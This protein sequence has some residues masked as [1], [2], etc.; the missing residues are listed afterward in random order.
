MPRFVLLLT[1]LLVP[2]ILI[3]ACDPSRTPLPD[4]IERDF[5]AIVER[6]TLGAL[7]V[8]NST[9]Y[10]VYRGQPMGY[11]YDLLRAFA[12]AHDLALDVRVV[13][14]PDSLFPLLMEGYGDVAA[15]RLIPPQHEDAR[16]HFTEAVY[17]AQPM[18]VQSEGAPDIP[19]PVVETLEEGA[20]TMEELPGELPGGV[21]PDLAILEAQEEIAIEARPITR[22]E[23]LAGETITLDEG[24][25]YSERLVELSDAV[26]GDIHVVEVSDA[27]MED[28]IR[29][30]AFNEV[31]LTVAPANLAELQA[32][33]F[34]NLVVRPSIG[35][36]LPRAWA[37]RPNSPQLLAELNAW[38]THPNQAG[39]MNRLYQRYF[40]DRRGYRERADSRYL[41]SETGR[42]SDY[43][44]LFKRYA[45]EVDW[46]WR[47]LASQAY[48]ESK[49]QPAARSWAGAQGL[50]QLM[51]PTAREFGVTNANDPDENVA[52]AVRFIAWLQRYWADKVH[53]PDENL[54]FVLAS[55][56][57]GHGHVEDARRLTARAGAD[58]TVWANVAFWL[59]QKS[60]PAVYRLP[61]VRYG[62]SRGYEP[63][64]YVEVI[65]DRFAHYRQFVT[66]EERTATAPTAAAGDGPEWASWH[67]RPA[68]GP[69]RASGLGN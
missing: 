23:D 19:D 1:S 16:I 63:V 24:S 20:E 6:D 13:Q 52:G 29:S 7:L 55:Y 41:T 69:V 17:V 15:A 58:D 49:F 68:R 21:S 36:P 51:P 53:D 57:T 65:L 34:T 47:L 37:V 38:L 5:D 54:K 66:P 27:S 45:P 22:P 61:V 43:D 44:E 31:D 46:D 50:L 12:E 2:L 40:V 67:E 28:L 11:E 32:A 30:V 35:D 39:L 33:R 62:F 10:F 3:A 56:N 42:L 26:T 4:P 59:L 25:P 9:S 8:S 18:V 60:D 64:H 48:Q 14:R